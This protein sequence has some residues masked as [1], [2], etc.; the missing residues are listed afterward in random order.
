MSFTGKE[1]DFI[2]LSDGASYTAAYRAA[3]PG[4][5]QGHFLGATKL[6]SVLAQANCVGLRFYYG[7]NPS[8]E[9]QLVVVGVDSNEND[10]I[11][12]A[13]LILDKSVICPPNCGNSNSLNS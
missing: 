12:G 8:G 2:T 13:S 1:G 4:S 9:K 6:K 3:N 11:T 7:I 5:T 10:L